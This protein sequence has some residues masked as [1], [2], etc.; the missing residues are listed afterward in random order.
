MSGGKVAAL[1]ILIF[2][3]IVAALLLVLHFLGVLLSAI[4]FLGL[5]ALIGLV[6]LVL[7]IG[8]VIILLA[9]YYM[10]K[11]TPV[12]QEYGNYT[13]DGVKGKEDWDKKG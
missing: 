13:L 6:I 5:Y 3:S 4:A 1:A 9:F 8:F 11:K 2:I 10:L 7:A 12:V